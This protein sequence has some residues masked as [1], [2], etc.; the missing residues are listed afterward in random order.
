MGVPPAGRRPVGRPP[1][2]SGARGA[3]LGIPYAHPP[4]RRCTAPPAFGSLPFPP[5]DCPFPR[6]L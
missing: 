3:A 2:R 4:R 5:L 6:Y 1:L